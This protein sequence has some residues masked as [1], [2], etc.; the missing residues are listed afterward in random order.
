VLRTRP[1]L[2]GAGL[3]PDVPFLG[4]SAV[5]PESRSARCA[6]QLWV[7]RSIVLLLPVLSFCGFP[8]AAP[9][10]SAVRF[11]CCSL[12]VFSLS[13]SG[14]W[15]PRRPWPSRA[16]N[17]RPLARRLRTTC[18]RGPSR[19]PR[20]GVT[21]TVPRR[22]RPGK[23]NCGRRTP[24]FRAAALDKKSPLAAAGLRS[25]PRR[26]LPTASADSGTTRSRTAARRPTK[27]P[28][29]IPVAGSFTFTLLRSWLLIRFHTVL[30]AARVPP[31]SS[32]SWS[33]SWER[34]RPPPRT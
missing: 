6:P 5:V 25:L 27:S 14:A 11:A 3:F 30:S 4:R 29:L 2:D 9:C 19:A 12:G 28:C 17:V 33:C 26:G 8:T 23:T 31:A 18:P 24:A 32:Y 7:R 10:R 13:A 34:D 22:R 20:P 21:Q 1:F 15:L 16:R